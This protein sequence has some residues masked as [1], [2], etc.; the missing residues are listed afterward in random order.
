M[1]YE[2]K[3]TAGTAQPL[4]NDSK[5]ISVD[6]QTKELYINAVESAARYRR[7]KPRL[8]T[9]PA[10]VIIK[11]L[12][13]MNTSGVPTYGTEFTINAQIHWEMEYQFDEESG[14]EVPK[15]NGFIVCHAAPNADKYKILIARFLDRQRGYVAPNQFTAQYVVV[16]Y[17][18]ADFMGNLGAPSESAPRTLTIDAIDMTE[19]NKT[20]DG[21]VIRQ[22]HCFIK[23]SRDQITRSELTS[24]NNY[25]KISLNG[26][27]I[28]K[29]YLNPKKDGAIFERTHHYNLYLT[30]EMGL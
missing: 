24:Q 22:G 19:N 12:S 30:K 2:V 14:R 25:F 16:S 27:V 28:G 11:P 29:Y 3:D 5:I 23:I 7:F 4:L 8:L 26:T 6:G 9:D 1:S 15:S 17:P 21:I 20:E 13:S 18:N 10:K